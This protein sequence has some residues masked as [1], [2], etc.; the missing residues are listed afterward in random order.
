[1]NTTNQAA[2]LNR[3]FAIADHLSFEEVADGF[4]V[5]RVATRHATSSIAL[6]GAHVMTYQQVGHAPVIW[7]S[8][9]AKFAPG[10]SIRG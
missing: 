3:R 8:K 7:L 6:Q 10:K 2:D 5:A 1:M 4:V 9:L